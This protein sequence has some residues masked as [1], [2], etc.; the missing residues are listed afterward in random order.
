MIM[1]LNK[2]NTG[3]TFSNYDTKRRNDTDRD[4]YR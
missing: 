2:K 4:K 3:V 1:I